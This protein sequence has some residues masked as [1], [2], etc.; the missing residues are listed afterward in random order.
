VKA[1]GLNTGGDRPEEHV[2]VVLPQGEKTTPEELAEKMK[3]IRDAGVKVKGTEM[4]QEV[5]AKANKDPNRDLKEVHDQVKEAQ[6]QDKKA[7]GEPSQK[8]DKKKKDKKKKDEGG[9]SAPTVAACKRDGSF[10]TLRSRPKTMEAEGRAAS[11]KAAGNSMSRKPVRAA[12][13]GALG[14]AAGPKSG[15]SR[16]SPLA[17][18]LTSSRT[19]GRPAAKKNGERV[20]KAVIGKASK[21]KKTGITK[22][23]SR[24]KAAG[25]TKALGTNRS[26]APKK[27]GRNKKAGPLGTTTRSSATRKTGKGDTAKR[28]A[29]KMAS[30]GGSKKQTFHTPA[31][32]KGSSKAKEVAKVAVA[33][34]KFAKKIHR[35]DLT[36]NGQRAV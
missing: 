27:A 33:S 36:T 23:G 15:A 24:A 25:V 5:M 29:T 18:Q 17:K 7:E 11:K 21:T 12:A 35:R 31:V 8:K 34:A 32:S 13:G 3:N 16:K 2:S 28:P 22:K 14:R 30:A 4:A 19:G 6:K 9:G 1:D 20:G 10:C 26:S